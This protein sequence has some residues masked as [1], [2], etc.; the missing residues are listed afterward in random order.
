MH[1]PDIHGYRRA[2]ETRILRPNF[3]QVLQTPRRHLNQAGDSDE[4]LWIAL[5]D[6]GVGI[7]IDARID[8]GVRVI[9]TRPQAVSGVR[10]AIRLVAENPERTGR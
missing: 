2:I 10:P 1:I 9:L 3:I 6:V 7:V 4:G 8:F 5:F